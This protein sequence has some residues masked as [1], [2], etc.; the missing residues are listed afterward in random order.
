MGHEHHHY[1]KTQLRGKRIVITISLNILI[2]VAQVIGGVLANSISLLSDAMHNF[3]D[4]ISLV[5]SYF[6]NL[7][8][9]RK[10]TARRTF[11]YKR[12]EIIAAFI[13]SATLIL[14]AF[15]LGKE[16]I[17]RFKEPEVVSADI[18]IYMA[19][20]SII[21]NTL[22]V[23]ILSKDAKDSMNM[24]SSYLHLLSDVITSIAVMVGGFAMKYF[25]LF[26]LDGVLTIII[27]IYLLIVSWKLFYESLKVL[28]QFVPENIDIKKISDELSNIDSVVNIHHVHIWQLSENDIHFECHVD[29][30]KDITISQF[31]SIVPQIREVLERYNINHYNIQPE[32]NTGDNKNIIV[33]E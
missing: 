7:L 8:S 25:N 5:I 33:Q 10:N 9:G 16:A 11:G 14:I 17:G 3:S 18:V 31:E 28:M 32:Y 23:S 12:A 13:N 27:A 29:M 21:I 6:A 15:I 22:S 20:L 2:T 1:N 19:L 4:V 24:R 26:W 30:E